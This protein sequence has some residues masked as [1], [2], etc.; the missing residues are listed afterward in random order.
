LNFSKKGGKCP[1]FPGSLP[2]YC[3]RSR[4]IRRLLLRARD[5]EALALNYLAQANASFQQFHPPLSANLPPDS[6]RHSAKGP[7]R[8]YFSSFS[9]TVFGLRS[10][11]DRMNGEAP[12]PAVVAKGVSPPAWILAV[13]CLFRKGPAHLAGPLFSPSRV[14]RF[15][16]VRD[17]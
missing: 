2:L 13:L 3:F 12:G 7:K 6:I 14:R 8:N 4:L 17:T 1:Y 5:P 15:V 10:L 16:S 9:E 11:I